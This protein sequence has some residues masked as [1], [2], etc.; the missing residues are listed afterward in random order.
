VRELKLQSEGVEGFTRSVSKFELIGVLIKL[1]DLADLS[2]NVEVTILFAGFG[3]VNSGA[4]VVF[5]ELFVRPF[6][7]G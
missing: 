5:S 1:K 2:A 6:S 3:E 7:E 4:H